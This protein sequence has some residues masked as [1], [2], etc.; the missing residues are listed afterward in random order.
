MA[1]RILQIDAG[2]SGAKWRVV[3]SA[4]V[5]ERGAARPDDDAALAVLARE[6]QSADELWLSS[7]LGEERQQALL[8]A[9]EVPDETPVR[10][11]RSRAHCAGVT[12]SYTEPERMGVDRWLALLAARAHCEARVCVVDAGTALT[13]DWL[14][15][16]GR[17]EGGYIIPGPALME[18]ALFSGTGRVRASDAAEWSASPGT[19]TASAVG[20]GIT[21]A[22]AGALREALHREG[23]TRS[24][25]AMPR[26]LVTGGY[27]QALIEVLSLAADYRNDLVFEGLEI[28][29]R[30][31]TS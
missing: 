1:A 2:N 21:L 4:R 8:D 9:L 29:V 14:A 31:E 13:I 3:S 10:Q 22:L 20:S 28:A 16:D 30:E 15:E 27:G 12:N 23:L 25:A 24:D 6:A 19:S 5:L 17:H 18:S 11:A 26:V 7:V